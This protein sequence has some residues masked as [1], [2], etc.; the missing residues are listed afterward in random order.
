M[1]KVEVDADDTGG[2]E[3]KDIKTVTLDKYH[4]WLN[5]KIKFVRSHTPALLPLPSA[6]PS[7]QVHNNHTHQNGSQV[8]QRY[9]CFIRANV[10][11]SQLNVKKSAVNPLMTRLSVLI[12]ELH[13]DKCRGKLTMKCGWLGTSAG[14]QP[15]SCRL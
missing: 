8:N 15:G 10:K 4:K 13:Q 12:G 14:D 11:L 1:E 9:I 2:E 3:G 6:S 5:L 7:V